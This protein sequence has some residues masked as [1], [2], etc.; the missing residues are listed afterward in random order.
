[1]SPCMHE[2]SFSP[3][4]SSLKEKI[5]HGWEESE[6]HYT[7]KRDIYNNPHTKE[8]TNS[9]NTDNTSLS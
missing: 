6:W 5:G 4:S 9:T 3:L 2:Y 8:K 7:F 1:V